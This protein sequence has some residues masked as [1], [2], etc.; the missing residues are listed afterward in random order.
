MENKYRTFKRILTKSHGFD[1]DTNGVLTVS[2]YYTGDEIKIDLCGID[3][4]MFE[5]IIC[6]DD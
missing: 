2:D 5:E 6:D 3:R 1:L 4:D